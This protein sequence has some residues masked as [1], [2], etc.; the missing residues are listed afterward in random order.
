[1]EQAGLETSL[2]Q[3]KAGFEFTLYPCYKGNFNVNLV[4][5]GTGDFTSDDVDGL[6]GELFT[7][8]GDRITEIFS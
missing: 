7:F 1:M 4:A 8:F 3:A 2:T 5:F 6:V